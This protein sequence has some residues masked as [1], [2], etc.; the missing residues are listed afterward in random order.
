MKPIV[1]Q[2]GQNVVDIDKVTKQFAVCISKVCWS[3][4]RSDILVLRSV[5]HQSELCVRNRNES[6]AVDSP[7]SFPIL[8]PAVASQNS[9][10]QEVGVQN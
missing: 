10:L 9:N 4:V 5:R 3:Q 1:C 2:F 6:V 7:W 8:L